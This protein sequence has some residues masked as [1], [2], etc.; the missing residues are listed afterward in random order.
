M[1]DALDASPVPADCASEREAILARYRRLR[2]VSVALHG[3]MLKRTSKHAILDQAR[4]FGLAVGGTIVAE[5]P[6]DLDLVFDL[7]LHTAPPGRSRAIDRYAKAAQ[8]APGSDEAIVLEAM[9]DARFSIWLVK[10]PHDA[11]GFI[12]ADLIGGTEA[13]LMDEGFEASALE[14]FL[15]AARLSKPDDFMMTSGVIVPVDQWLLNELLTSLPGKL[16]DAPLIEAVADRRFARTLYRI[17]LET[18]VMDGIEM[19]PVG[20][21]P[22]E[23]AA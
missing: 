3:E 14:G 18:G 12:V 13:W 9:C 2:A 5:N 4:K 10:Q 6:D 22:G 17:A 1:N 19:R 7:L 15:F 11:A 21:P 20:L 8:F 23:A 16:A